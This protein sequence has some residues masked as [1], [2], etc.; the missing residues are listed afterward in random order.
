MNDPRFDS[1]SQL[2]SVIADIEKNIEQE[3]GKHANGLTTDLNTHV[4]D[5]A[6]AQISILRAVYRT[7]NILSNT[8][9]E[10]EKGKLSIQRLNK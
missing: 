7:F 6:R 10:A 4:R 3:F 2:L 9:Y 1:A 8:I 5:T